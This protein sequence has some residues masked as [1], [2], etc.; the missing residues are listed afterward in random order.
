MYE[1]SNVEEVI[2][3]DSQVERHLYHRGSLDINGITALNDLHDGTLID[4]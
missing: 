3:A 1:L 4:T 2:N